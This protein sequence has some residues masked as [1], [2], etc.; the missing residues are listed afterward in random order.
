MNEEKNDSVRHALEERRMKSNAN[1]DRTTQA[2]DNAAKV[3]QF[4]PAAAYAKGYQT[5]R[6]IDNKLTGGKVSRGL[7]KTANAI[8]PGLKT[9]GKI[10]SSGLA[11]TATGAASKLGNKQG[12]GSNT[13][14]S[15]PSNAKPDSKNSKKNDTGSKDNSSKEKDT[16]DSKKNKSSG[17]S[18]GKDGKKDSKGKGLG[19]FAFGIADNDDKKDEKE[20]SSLEVLIGQITPVKILFMA[21]GA[22]MTFLILFIVIFID[23]YEHKYEFLTSQAFGEISGNSS[24]KTKSGTK[25]GNVTKEDDKS[26][27]SDDYDFSEYKEDFTEPTGE[28]VS[29]ARDNSNRDTDLKGIKSIFPKRIYISFYNIG[30]IFTKRNTICNGDECDS[31]AEVKFYQKVSDIAYRYKNVYNVELDWPLIVASVLIKSYDKEETFAANLNSYTIFELN[32]KKKTMSLDWEYNYEDIPG[33]DYLS[34]N[35]SSYDLQILAKN[36]VK[37]KTTQTCTKSN[38][39]SSSDPKPKVTVVKTLESED[40]EDYKIEADKAN[41]GA[42][43][44]YLVCDAGTKY[45]IKSTYTLDKD[46]YDE[47]LDEYIEKRYYI[48]GDG[49]SNGSGG[50]SEGEHYTIPYGT[51]LSSTLINVAEGE[52]GNNETDK[53]YLKYTDGRVEAWCADFVSWAISHTEYDGVKLYPDVIH[54]T[55]P[56]VTPFLA[57]FNSSPDPNIKFYVNTNADKF[58]DRGPR[59]IPKP[60]DIIFFDWEADWLA[61]GDDVSHIGI[62]TGSD[63]NK[64]YTIEGNT[65]DM[66]ARKIRDLSS[67]TTLGFGSWY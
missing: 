46:K 10:G 6:N 9:A 48:K 20:K 2:L 8:T 22:L 47:F 45:N 1:A 67:P 13:G 4:T 15:L 59:Y 56:G 7:S 3:A 39:P 62:V 24:K 30:N 38:T 16:K 33:Y 11:N 12:L 31:V 58:K 5:F 55:N 25:I 52:L 42:D 65:G 57:F 27:E 41:K 18:S 35:D 34:P 63:G 64:V 14:S 17:S 54:I 53:S 66:V 61:P 43:G 51:D 23:S 19:L 29:N 60:G 26:Y 50:A 36:M 37:K 32:N 28:N 44:L 49:S 21:I 40:V